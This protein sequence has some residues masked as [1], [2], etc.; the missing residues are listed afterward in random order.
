MKLLELTSRACAVLGV[1]VLM[2]AGATVQT[3][4]AQTIIINL[5]VCAVG[6]GGTTC[7]ANW[8]AIC[9]NGICQLTAGPATYPNGRK[10]CCYV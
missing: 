2:Y 8:F 4:K 9:D 5:P 1:A 3:A 10:F 6:G 7:V